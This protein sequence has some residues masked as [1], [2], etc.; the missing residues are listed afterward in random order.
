MYEHETQDARDERWLRDEFGEYERGE[1]TNHASVNSVSSGDDDDDGDDDSFYDVSRDGD[2]EENMAAPVLTRDE[3]RRR[4]AAACWSSQ[5]G[6]EIASSQVACL[7]VQWEEARQ[8]Y[9]DGL[10]AH[11]NV[12]KEEE[13]EQLP[14]QQQGTT[15]PAGLQDV[16][17]QKEAFVV[18][19]DSSD[20]EL[21][22][23]V[24]NYVFVVRLGNRHD[25]MT[26]QPFG[27]NLPHL[28]TCMLPYYVEYSRKK[29]AKV[30]LR[31]MNGGSHL[32]YGS[33]IIVET[34]SDDTMTSRALLRN[35]MRI[36]RHDCGY[37]GLIIKRRI[38]YNIVATGNVNC[39]LCLNVLRHHFRAA[40]EKKK[41]FS[42]VIIKLEDVERH[43]ANRSYYD[44]ALAAATI[45]VD[46]DDDGGEYAYHPDYVDEEVADRALIDTINDEVGGCNSSD[47]P[48]DVKIKMEPGVE[49][50]ERIALIDEYVEAATS[51]M[52]FV[53]DATGSTVDKKTTAATENGT[54]LIF[55]EGQIICTGCKSKKRLLAAY[56]KIYRLLLLCRETPENAELE[57]TLMRRKST[58][59]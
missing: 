56:Q 36:L 8:L 20:M 5:F 21:S 33:A 45:D 23:D 57:K 55:K 53:A 34:G 19:S 29:F 1:F 15:T 2:E 42:G 10:C 39:G 54:F 28:A 41:N 7:P 52:D 44:G 17:Q 30:N 24:Q 18:K 43:F 4:E 35:T 31:Y 9:L 26:G 58:T 50:D 6:S 48:V 47:T 25:T 13:E 27:F 14:Q 3:E 22:F 11:T 49:E 51:S 59:K 40:S 32:I 46:S 16:E 38:C 37:S 12:K